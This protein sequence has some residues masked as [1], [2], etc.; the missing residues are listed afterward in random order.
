MCR[1]DQNNLTDVK[2]PVEKEKDCRKQKY[3]L[4]VKKVQTKMSF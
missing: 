4:P 2:T 1:L 3:R